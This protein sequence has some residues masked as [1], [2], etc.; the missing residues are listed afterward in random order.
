MLQPQAAIHRLLKSG[1]T[2]T[3]F[4]CASK[5]AWQIK[6]KCLVWD[7]HNKT[8]IATQTTP[9]QN[10]KSVSAGQDVARIHTISAS[11]MCFDWGDHLVVSTVALK[12]DALSNKPTGHLACSCRCRARVEQVWIRMCASEAMCINE[13]CA[14]LFG[15]ASSQ[16]NARA[17]PPVCCRLMHHVG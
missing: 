9:P 13:S 7:Q 10:N 11:P 14:C 1:R 6:S 16:A 5:H 4:L 8:S 3:Y 2:H 15:P 12:A 17:K